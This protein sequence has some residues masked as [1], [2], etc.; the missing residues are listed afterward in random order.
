M[1]LPNSLSQNVLLQQQLFVQ[2]EG[3]HPHFGAHPQ[4]GSQ[5][6]AGPVKQGEQHGVGQAGAQIGAAGHGIAA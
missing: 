3:A 5:G 6:Q 2:Q 1:F 4:V